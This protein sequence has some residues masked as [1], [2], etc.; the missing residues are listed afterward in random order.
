MT[1]LEQ[2]IAAARDKIA[3]EAKAKA[4]LTV[5]KT[6]K[7]QAAR[8]ASL[9]ESRKLQ[10]ELDWFPRAL[11]LVVEEWECACG[12]EGETP[13]GMFIYKEHARMANSSVLVAPR[14]EADEGNNLPKRIKYTERYLPICSHCCLDHG[15]IDELVDSRVKFGPAVPPAPGPFVQD[16]LEKRI[17]E[18][19]DGEPAP[20]TPDDEEEDD[21]DA[22]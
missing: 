3:T 22:N 19:E 11:V 10:N 6:A 4:A 15:F 7:T 12:K 1:P 16:W 18:P 8:D 13:L 2:L 14:H 17:P 5:S 20:A 21:V 9:A